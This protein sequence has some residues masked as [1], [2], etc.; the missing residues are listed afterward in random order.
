MSNFFYSIDINKIGEI[1]VKK[2]PSVVNL[3]YVWCFE[4][5]KDTDNLI[6][7]HLQ[8]S[9]TVNFLFNERVDMLRCYQRLIVNTIGKHLSIVDK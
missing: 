2:A 4:L 6:V 5:S 9:A 7:F 3:D 1:D 8:D